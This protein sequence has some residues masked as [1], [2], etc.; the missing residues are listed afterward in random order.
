MKKII[1]IGVGAQGSTIAKHLDQHPQ[2]SEVICADY[3]ETSARELEKT[4]DKAKALKL[5]ASKVN[6]VIRA[7][8]GCDLIVN[9]LP[10]EYNLVIMEAALGVQASY[11]DMAGPMEDIGFVESYKLLFSQW[12][13]KFKEKGLTALVGCGSA[14]GLANVIARESVEKLDTC[15]IIG[16]YIYEGVWTNRFTPFW[17][18]PQV[19]FGDM[20]YKTFRYENGKHVTDR[21]FSR[22]VIMRLKGI[23]REVR[24]VDHE[25]DEPVTMGL[26]ADKV[27]KGV[28]NVDFKYGGCGVEL[29]EL[30]FKIGLL[31]KKSVTVKGTRIVPLDLVLQLCPSAPKYPDEIKAIIDQGVA[32]EEGAFLVRV[33]GS[34]EG[35]PVRIDNY[36]NSPGL[37]EA[38]EKTGLSHESYLT[39]QCAAIFTKMMVDGIFSENGVHAP[40]QLPADARRY[41][42]KH[43]AKLGITVEQSIRQRQ[44]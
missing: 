25:H 22:P 19:A 37:V 33:D 41:Y 29:S 21:P 10:L 1:I 35:K 23:D 2:V 13:Q 26:L 16:I 28:T 30:L 34:K 17:W 12:H 8:Q 36:V 18:S 42:F 31:S 32:A 27:L 44:P 40:E 5:D 20:A 15:D 43:L 38:F 4:L 6:H 14:P 7:A 24:L 3:D 39:G 9:G 11:F